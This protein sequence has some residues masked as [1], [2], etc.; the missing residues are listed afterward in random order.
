MIALS[1][2]INLPFYVERTVLEII[3][4]SRITNSYPKI[5]SVKISEYH[6]VSNIF[7]A[8]RYT[9]QGLSN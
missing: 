4:L 3:E 9:G 7:I 1:C 6:V 2:G 5:Q 8:I